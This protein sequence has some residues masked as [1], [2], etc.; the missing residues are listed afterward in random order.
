MLEDLREDELCVSDGEWGARWD[1][2]LLSSSGVDGAG[3]SVDGD[4]GVV[5]TRGGVVPGWGG[6]GGRPGAGVL[7]P[8]FVQGYGQ[9]GL[10]LLSQRFSVF[11]GDC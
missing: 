2:Q 1:E 4:A 6:G 3:F 7:A 9:V 11:V 8:R 10:S 5:A